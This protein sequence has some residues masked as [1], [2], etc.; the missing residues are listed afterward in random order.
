MIEG[1]VVLR[2]ICMES[3]LWWPIFCH[4]KQMEGRAESVHHYTNGDGALAI[5]E[6]GHLWFTERAHLN[7]PSEVSHGIGIAQEILRDNG[8]KEQAEKLGEIAKSVFREFLFFSA[9]FSF[10]ADDACQWKKY[11]DN[12]HGVALTFRT[13][14][15]SI[16]TEPHEY[17]Q[18][19]GLGRPNAFV[20]PMSYSEAK[21]RQIIC[22]IIN[23]WDGNNYDELSDHV[24]MISSMFKHPA[25]KSE[26]EYRFFVHKKKSETLESD[27]FKA[28]PRDG[29]C[30]FYLD[31]PLQHWDL[32]GAS[33]PICRI[34]LGPK[35]SDELEKK[36]S[37]LKN[38]SGI[39]IARSNIS[40]R[41]P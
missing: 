5:L 16:F 1:K 26:N 34:T 11:G 18:S 36:L 13:A 3:K 9:S 31:L 7:D 2:E 14:Y 10:E 8:K 23:L 40:Y 15:P 33:P 12:G 6:R 29:S 30:A 41:S 24:F 25:W 19:L 39:E 21:L 38:I 35:A 20:C 22:E 27:L 28:R 37:D 17:V 32:Q 4:I